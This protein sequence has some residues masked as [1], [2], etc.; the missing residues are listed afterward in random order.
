M[1]EIDLASLSDQ[2]LYQ[3]FVELAVKMG[4]VYYRSRLSR[5]FTPERMNLS[6]EIDSRRPAIASVFLAG[7][8][9]EDPWVRLGVVRFCID[10][11]R[12]EAL[13]VLKE[14]AS[15]E[16]HPAAVNAAISHDHYTKGDT[17][18]RETREFAKKI[19]D[20]AEASGVRLRGK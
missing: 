6:A 5:R 11:G 1:N 12:D 3:R 4:E 8:R 14:V 20:R 7:L 2:K 17:I 19:L 18:G 10:A 13:A 15:L 9:H 16:Y